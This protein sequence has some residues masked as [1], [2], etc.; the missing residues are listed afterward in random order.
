MRR[1]EFIAPVDAM[2]GNLSGN[3]ELRYPTD[4]N[5]AWDAPVGKRS[6]ANNYSTR[7]VG[8]KRSRDGQKYFAV[9]QRSATLI[10]STTKT[11][12]ALLA[13]SSVIANILAQEL[14]VQTILLAF[15]DASAAKRSGWTFKR[16]LQDGAR[17]ALAG[18]MHITFVAE[19]PTSVQVS[20][21]TITNPYIDTSDPEGTVSIR[22]AF[23]TELLVKF[24]M[25]LAN[26]PITFTVNGRQG[27]ARS[28]DSFMGLAQDEYINI[29]GI[30][31][32]SNTKVKMGEGY[33]AFTQNGTAYGAAYMKP[34]LENG[35]AGIPTPS[36]YLTDTPLTPH[37]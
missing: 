29:L 19:G 32:E 21:V 34:I 3:Q 4:N 9:K 13:A 16:Y 35:A 2:R 30:E 22:S 18:K 17:D 24:W 28:G 10:N 33:L 20:S 31:L 27:I 6:Y 15:Y 7:Y 11:N 23:P 37:S 25:Q 26:N 36:Y 14:S 12:M 5:K 8:A 1:I